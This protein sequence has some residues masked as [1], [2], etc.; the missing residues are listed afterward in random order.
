ME[1]LIGLIILTFA[2]LGIA[3]YRLCEYRGDVHLDVTAADN[4]DAS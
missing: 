1:V 4:C 3:R 2:L